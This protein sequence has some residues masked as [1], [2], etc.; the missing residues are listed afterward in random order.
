[1]KIELLVPNRMY[2]QHMREVTS[3]ASLDANNKIVEDGLYSEHIFGPVGS[4]ER[5]NRFS[6]YDLHTEII[7]PRIYDMLI[8]VNTLY[9]DI[10]SGEVRAKFIQGNYKIDEDGETGYEFFKSNILDMQIKKGVLK[11]KNKKIDVINKAISNQTITSRYLLVLP[12]GMRDITVDGDRVEEDDLN[13]NYKRVF[14]AKEILKYQK[15]SSVYSS[16]HNTFLIK[17]Q[18]DIVDLF[19]AVYIRLKGKKGFIG[20]HVSN[21][22]VEYSTNNVIAGHNEEIED[23]EDESYDVLNSTSIGLLQYAKA[24]EPLAKHGILKYF[25]SDRFNDALSTAMVYNDDLKLEEVSVGVKVVKEWTTSNG[26]GGLINK[27]KD[28]YFRELP[29]TIKD[30]KGNKRNLF[31]VR[32]RGDR[33]EVIDGH[34]PKGM[35]VRPLTYGE[36][37]YISMKDYKDILGGTMVRY[38][39]SDQASTNVLKFVVN[40][41]AKSRTVLITVRG[42][43]VEIK[44]YPIIGSAWNESLAPSYVLLAGYRADFDGVDK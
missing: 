42:V 6:Y 39:I 3:T 7:H 41:T 5:L 23:L 15:A 29:V 27:F 9:K 33:V 36:M 4:G 17:L 22:R 44:K 34:V 2:V 19:S 25:S 12:A 1:M 20:G 14:N 24:S 43:E 32:D 18:H 8:T 35:N 13:N 38:P 40:T 11:S 30:K 37:L 21:R 16:L 28:Y 10:I 31:Y 26:L